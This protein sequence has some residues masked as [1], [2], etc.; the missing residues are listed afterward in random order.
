MSSLLIFFLALGIAAIG[1]LR[2]FDGRVSW[3]PHHVS[4]LIPVVALLLFGL[5]DFRNRKITRDYAAMGWWKRRVHRHFPLAF[6]GSTTIGGLTFYV[7]GR[8]LDAL[9]RTQA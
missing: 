5:Y 6:F 2:S 8:H 4:F 9:Y 1:S 7:Y 3:L